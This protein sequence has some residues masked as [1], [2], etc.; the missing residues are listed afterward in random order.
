MHE[1][2]NGEHCVCFPLPACYSDVAVLRPGVFNAGNGV[3]VALGEAELRRI[4]DNFDP[5]YLL[6][7]LNIDHDASGPALG[8]VTGLR[9]DGEYLRA[10]IRVSDAGLAERIEN[11]EF[12]SRSAEIYPNLDGRGPALRAVALLGALPPAVKGLPPMRRDTEPDPAREARTCGA[13]E[14]LQHP[15]TDETRLGPFCVTLLSEVPMGNETQPAAADK[16]VLLAE[17]NRRLAEENR[18]LL[19]NERQREI[20]V[21]LN[22]LRRAGRLTPALEQAGIEKLLLAACET[23]LVVRFSEGDEEPLFETLHRL[24]SALPVSVSFGETDGFAEFRAP[25]GLSADE[26]HVAA[27]LGLSPDEYSELRSLH[28]G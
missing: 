1:S 3:T 25:G 24:F 13:P 23:P 22:E 21:F 17:E 20:A 7:T 11:G 5:A 10:D 27:Q 12:P 28:Q 15:G 18:R 19:L 4:A 26:Q 14:P 8:R 9:F 16:A 2:T 6:P